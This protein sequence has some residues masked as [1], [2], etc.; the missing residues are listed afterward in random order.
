MKKE[1][2]TTDDPER[3]SELI[4]DLSNDKLQSQLYRDAIFFFKNNQ[5]G[6]LSHMM[7]NLGVHIHNAKTDLT[8]TSKNL[9]SSLEKQAD[10][11]TTSI[12]DANQIIQ[13]A[14]DSSTN[15]SKKLNM[16]TALLV[17]LTLFTILVSGFSSW[18]QYQQF[19]LNKIQLCKEIEMP[20]QTTMNAIQVKE[21]LRIQN[22]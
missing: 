4:D 21:N 12:Q 9:E 17:I 15:I 18:V 2:N 16:L 1:I 20:A 19:K 7:H 13:T 8:K 10:Q 6:S 14:S 3:L 22:E 11:L 5:G